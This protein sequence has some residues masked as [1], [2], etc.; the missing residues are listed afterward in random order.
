MSD[1]EPSQKVQIEIENENDEENVDTEPP[2]QIQPAQSTQPTVTITRK[3]ITDLTE[4][5][6]AK[7]ISDA[8]NGIENEFY[9]VK[10]LKNGST[11]ISLKKQTKAQELIKE[12]ESN[13]ERSAPTPTT[14]Y[15]TDNQ[16]LF[17]HIIN[18]ESQ[19]NK[20][21]AKHKKLKKRYNDLEGYLY[22][23]DSDDDAKPQKQTV[24]QQQQQ[25]EQPIPVVQPVEVPDV[26]PTQQQQVSPASLAQQPYVQRRFVRSWRDLRPQ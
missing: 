20:L 2:K 5:E 21:R 15:L 6:R 13:P 1:Q 26:Q 24:Q 19:Y 17:E 25:R 14:R 18:L 8:Q 11:R 16:L 4:Q 12:N 3:K 22:A 7:L 10:L 23:D 9:N